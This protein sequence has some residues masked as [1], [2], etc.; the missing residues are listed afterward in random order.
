M[1]VNTKYKGKEY[2]VAFTPSYGDAS[3]GNCGIRA[4]S[5]VMVTTVSVV[6][7]GTKTSLFPKIGTGFGGVGQLTADE[8]T[9]VNCIVSTI[10]DAISEA[11]YKEL[12]KKYGHQK[13][14]Y[15]YQFLISDGLNGDRITGNYLYFSMG[16]R[17]SDFI[18]WLLGPKSKGLIK[19]SPGPITWNPNHP[20]E[21]LPS[22]IQAVLFTFED[23]SWYKANE[24]C[25]IEFTKE[26]EALL[27]NYKKAYIQTAPSTYST[28]YWQKWKKTFFTQLYNSGERKE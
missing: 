28:T 20:N 1:Q 23:T 19:A 25:E 5:N 12:F 18:G 3:S 10:R 17:T 7:F 2:V 14:L 21:G 26:Q 16:Y 4:I 15:G 24:N 27:D 6:E 13:G 11:V 9:L 8:K 22:L